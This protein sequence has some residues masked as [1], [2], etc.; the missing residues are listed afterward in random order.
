MAHTKKVSGNSRGLKIGLRKKQVRYLMQNEIIVLI[1]STHATRKYL[2]VL[3]QQMF[4][5]RTGSIEYNALV[6]KKV[7]RTTQVSIE[8]KL[9]TFQKKIN[10]S[11]KQMYNLIS[12]IN[13]KKDCF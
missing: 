5:G 3:V 1:Q 10:F 4:L 11:F 13:I 12:I 2:L 8:K 6:F 9:K 7:K